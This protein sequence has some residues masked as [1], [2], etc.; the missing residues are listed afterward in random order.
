[1]IALNPP[2]VLC[3]FIMIILVPRA[4]VAFSHV[5]A[6]S[7]LAMGTRLT[8]SAKHFQRSKYENVC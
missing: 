2:L 1:M 8:L 4:Y 5:A 3:H 6:T 7:F